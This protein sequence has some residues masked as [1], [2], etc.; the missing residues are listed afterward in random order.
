MKNIPILCISGVIT[1]CILFSL[2]QAK[3]SYDDAIAT[4]QSAFLLEEDDTSGDIFRCTVGN[5]PAKTDA[6]IQFSYVT[7]L[8]LE[9]DDGVRFTMPTILN[10]RYTPSDTGM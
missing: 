3:E 7:E 2:L 8:V 10:P 4:G 1:S 5:L 9:K 6:Q